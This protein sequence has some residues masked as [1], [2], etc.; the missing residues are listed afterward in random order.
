MKKFFSI[1]IIFLTCFTGV[2][3]NSENLKKLLAENK[4]IESQLQKISE[5]KISLEGQKNFL[6]KKIEQLFVEKKIFLEKKWEFQKEL[7]KKISEK[8]KIENFSEINEDEILKFIKTLHKEEKK[9]QTNWNE[10]FVK[11][12]LLNSSISKFF[13]ELKIIKKIEKISQKFLQND[14]LISEKNSE[15]IKKISNLK[16][17]ISQ[18]NENIL[19]NWTELLETQKAQNTLLKYY[20]QKENSFKEKIEKNKKTILLSL[21]ETKKAL[22]EQKKIDK[23]I[24]IWYKKIK[25]QEG[26]NIYEKSETIQWKSDPYSINWFSNLDDKKFIWPVDKDRWI[27]AYFMDPE[28]KKRT[29]VEHYWMDIRAKQWTEIKAPANAFVYKV[30]DWWMDYSY[31][32][33]AH[34]WSIQTVYGHISKSLVK[35]WDVILKW[36]VFALSWWTPWTPWAWSLTTWPHLHLEFHENW[37]PVNPLKFLKK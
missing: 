19:K 27:T 12:F 25:K 9:I 8:T 13:Q 14:E 4:K 15:E 20:S 26:G 2:F 1:I 34:K 37:K 33:L 7:E 31:I 3:A 24:S 30:H 6:E 16:E 28:Y 35:E 5:E 22:L 17:D 36:Q 23:K 32:I 11:L 21:L 29:W 10:N 18:L